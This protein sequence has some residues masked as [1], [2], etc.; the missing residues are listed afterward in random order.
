MWGTIYKRSLA[1]SDKRLL[2]EE[3]NDLKEKNKR[4][5][6]TVFTDISCSVSPLER[7]ISLFFPSFGLP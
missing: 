7:L 5:K 4:G 3:N 1:E 6:N 2:G